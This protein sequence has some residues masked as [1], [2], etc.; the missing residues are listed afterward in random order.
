M[1]LLSLGVVFGLAASALTAAVPHSH[2]VHEKRDATVA[3]KWVKREKLP[4]DTRLPMRVGLKQRNLHRGHDL[5]MDVS[6]PESPNYSKHWNSEEVVEM[7][8]PEQSTVDTVRTWLIDSGID[9]SRITH[10]D[11]KGWLAF[12]ATTEEAET[13]LLTEYHLYGHVDGHMTPACESYHVPKYIQE[14]L[15]Y[16]T[17][18]IRLLAPNKR[19]SKRTFRAKNGFAPLLSKAM[20]GVLAQTSIDDLSICD[21]LI[22][23]ACIRALYGIPEVPEYPN[24]QPRSDNSLGIFEDGDYY[25]QEDLDLFFTNQTR[26]I[27]AGTH[28]VPAFID[29]A[30]APVPVWE[31]GG[32]SSL[33]FELAIPLLY[34]QTV[35]L[36]QT[37]DLYNTFSKYPPGLFNNF[38]DAIDGSYCTYSAFGETGNDRMPQLAPSSRR[39][40]QLIFSEPLSI[41]PTPIPLV[42]KASYSVVFTNQQRQ[43]NEFMKLGLQGH[44]FIYA[45]GDL[46]VS[47]GGPNENPIDGCLGPYG[48]IFTP[49]WPVNCPYITVVGATK[50]YPNHTVYDPES[51][52]VDPLFDPWS[53]PYSSGGGFSNIYPRPSYQRDAVQNYFGRHDPGYKYYRG[54]D[55][56][57]A[58]GGRY[59]RLGRGYPDVAANGDNIANFIG[60]Y[61]TKNGGTSASTPIF[62]S[63]INRINEQ[64]LNAG[65]KVLGFLNPALYNN[66][67][68]LNDITNGSN[69]GCG[70]EGFRA[71][72]GWDPVTGLGTPNYPKMV[73]YFMGLP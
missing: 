14:H 53:I 33:D 12:D 30:Q 65:K 44:S 10:S 48:S 55:S 4:A 8:A 1:H 73:K 47:G 38:L 11:N 56:F 45:S 64:R 2:I 20:S 70:T 35:T 71:V 59:N 63:I 52:V 51:A 50:I 54:N 49:G 27:P 69:P 18:G 34:P 25:A 13:L 5:L 36:Y 43:C 32:E 60:G 6:H 3:K 39:V 23:P 31:A 66:P 67:G 24:N 9:A 62:A 19:R 61:F 16:I 46:G 37:D 72:G 26:G 41:Q 68:M 58:N 29:G 42:F 21:Q 28:P 22:T 7:F 40:K 15:D 57:G 17:P